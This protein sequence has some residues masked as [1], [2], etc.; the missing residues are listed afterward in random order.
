MLGGREVLAVQPRQLFLEGG[1]VGDLLG[2]LRGASLSLQVCQ[3]D[4]LTA[5]ATTAGGGCSSG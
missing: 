3:G 2:A 1:D 5:G 4:A